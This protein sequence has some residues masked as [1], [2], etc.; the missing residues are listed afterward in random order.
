MQKI[1]GKIL[2][3]NEE[4]KM[5]EKGDR[6]AVGVSGGKDSLILLEGLCRIRK[7]L[8]FGIELIAITIDL[9][10]S[11]KEEQYKSMKQICNYYGVLYI[12]EKTEIFDIVFNV[13]KQEKNPCSLCSK[14]KKGVLNT[15]AKENGCNKVAFGHHLDDV[16]ETFLMNLFIEG[17]IACFSPITFFSRQNLYLIRPLIFAQ[18]RQIKRAIKDLNF[19]V[20]KILCP[21]DGYTYREKIKE[22]LREKEKEDKGFKKRIFGA[23]RRSGI[24]GWG[25]KN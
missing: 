18:E 4:F 22:F 20:S 12:I 13:K 11:D 23:L 17:R 6:I 16:V 7:F 15:I 25:F 8:N 1:V 19:E 24:S 10:F 3:A 5:F 2:K 21:K 14:L 9:S